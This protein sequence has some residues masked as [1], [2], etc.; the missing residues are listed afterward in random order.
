M[1]C[2]GG[3][4]LQC[5]PLR[6]PPLDRPDEYGTVTRVSQAGGAVVASNWAS[7]LDVFANFDIPA[8]TQKEPPPPTAQGPSSQAPAQVHT[9]CRESCFCAHAHPDTAPHAF[10]LPSSPPQCS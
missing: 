7:N 4:R 10:S 9:A 1:R 3:L 5:T 6:P 8:F 2:G